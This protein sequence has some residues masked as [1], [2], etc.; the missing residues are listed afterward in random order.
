MKKPFKTSNQHFFSIINQI[1][2]REINIYR[3]KIRSKKKYLPYQEIQK[4]DT[5]LYLRE[6]RQATEL[7]HNDLIPEQ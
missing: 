4:Q 1:S 7:L 2:G 6:Q 3:E 5:W